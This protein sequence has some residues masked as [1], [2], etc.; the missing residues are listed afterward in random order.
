MENL[1]M[2]KGMKKAHET[3]NMSTSAMSKA[4]C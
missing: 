3:G 4:V 2:T 1:L